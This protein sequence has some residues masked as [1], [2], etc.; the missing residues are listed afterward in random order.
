MGTIPGGQLEVGSIGDGGQRQLQISPEAVIGETVR[1]AAR[2]HGTA[3]S[4]ERRLA[5]MRSFFALLLASRCRAL[6]TNVTLTED[7]WANYS[8][9]FSSLAGR[10]L[11]VAFIP[12]SYEVYADTACG[13]SAGESC[14]GCKWSGNVID[15]YTEIQRRA[16]F[17]IQET[18]VSPE[19]QARFPGYTYSACIDDVATG[20]LDLCLSTFWTWDHRLRVAQF[21]LPFGTD[22]IG[23]VVPLSDAETKSGIRAWMWLFDPVDLSVWMTFLGAILMTGLTLFVTEGG[24]ESESSQFALAVGSPK[25]TAMPPTLATRLKKRRP[26]ESALDEAIEE[27]GSHDMGEVL[28]NGLLAMM[29]QGEEAH[30]ELEV[31]EHACHWWGPRGHLGLCIKRLFRVLYAV[32]LAMLSSGGNLHGDDTKPRSL[33]GKFIVLVSRQ[34][35]CATRIRALLSR[36]ARAL[37]SR[38]QGISVFST[39]FIA[40]YTSQLTTFSVKDVQSFAANDL[41]DLQSGSRVCMLAGLKA[42]LDP[43][44]AATGTNSTTVPMGSEAE[45][46][47]TDTGTV[48]STGCDAVTV[49]LRAISD[50]YTDVKNCKSVGLSNLNVLEVNLGQPAAPDVAPALTYWL[51]ELRDVGM[52]EEIRL[53]WEY[54]AITKCEL[55]SSDDG[56]A[57]IGFEQMKILFGVLAFG[58]VF[59]IFEYAFRLCRGESMMR[60]EY[61]SNS[62]REGYKKTSKLKEIAMAAEVTRAF[63]AMGE[64]TPEA[65]SDEADHAVPALAKAFSNRLRLPP[66]GSR[67]RNA[68]TNL[69]SFGTGSAAIAPTA[70]DDEAA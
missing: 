20:R 17:S 6:V 10:T 67:G 28:K 63:A 44:L 40:L 62:V 4:R 5:R 27:A 18:L 54:E 51:A 41:V 70:S 23:L 13:C 2:V 56:A 57:P 21:A 69:A 48:F 25:P 34:A 11:R 22:S 31:A 9:P 29:A 37:S 26:S 46:F 47:G 39:M 61:L 36:R 15:V 16:N 33:G 24:C 60:N 65:K 49:S 32:F 66:M 14:V 7:P 53:K 8:T 52:L 19:A 55:E 68:A 50:K 12:Y 43:I 45:M 42:Q 30:E 38:A 58:C 3:V 35:A 64:T 1:A 59:A